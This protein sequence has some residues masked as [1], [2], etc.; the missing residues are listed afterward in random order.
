MKR[1]CLMCT[2]YSYGPIYCN[3]VS[4]IY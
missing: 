3:F 4:T 1:T 2:S